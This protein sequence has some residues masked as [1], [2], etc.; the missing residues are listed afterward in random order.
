MNA[1]RRIRVVRGSI[2]SVIVAAALS[3]I[4]CGGW[5]NS[6]PTTRSAA[7][8]PA[9]PAAGPLSPDGDANE[10]IIRELE[11]K[12]RKDPEDFVAYN[13]LANYYLQRQRETGDVAYLDLATRAARASLD[14]LPAEQNPAGLGA[15]AQSEIAT[16]DFAAARD[17]ALLLTRL[18][19]HK[20]YSHQI[21]GDALLELGEYERADAVFGQM[22]RAAGGPSVTTET[23]MARLATLRGETN[24][25]E[26]YLKTALALATDE[27]VP[28][29]E[30]V[31]W[32]RWQL[33]ETAF[34]RGDYDTAETHYR[35]ALVSFPGYHHAV[36]ALGRTRA[37]RGDLTAAI[38]QYEQAVRIIP[39]PSFVAA[40]GDL[41]H[42]AGRD[43]EAARQYALVEQM[44]RL[45]KFNGALYNR[46]LAI[47]YADHDLQPE[48][49]YAL[50]AKEYEVRR[51]IYGADALA[52]TALKAGKV[53]QAQGAIK[54]ALRLGTQDARLFYHA[55]MI[56]RAAGDEAGAR[57]QLGR[58][59]ELNA[60]FDARQSG[61]AR[62]TLDE[63]K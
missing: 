48:E 43:A 56:A 9:V 37:A 54:E 61:I 5:W 26:R 11:A 7:S 19:P 13:K 34:A 14:I 50:A 46:Q 38:A 18:I 15:L 23:R 22:K 28:S 59:V 25:A 29:R 60:G 57:E 35:D 55:G 20:S 36:A 63:I 45:S 12:V 39:D 53:A 3:S 17:H 2:V 6:N 24:E 21:L 49:A 40:L 33:G 32:C 51:D 8:P 30:S 27:A 4:S 31:A 47:F 10:G 16:H 44:A 1:M 52:W 42:L 41:Y 62:Q 58:A